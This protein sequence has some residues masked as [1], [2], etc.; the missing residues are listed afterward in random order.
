MHSINEK[1]KSLELRAEGYSYN[2]IS[3]KLNVPKSTLSNWLKNLPFLPNKT[4]NESVINSQ[5]KAIYASR[6]NRIL[7]LTKA[8]EYA[9]QNIKNLSPREIFLIGMGIYIGEGSKAYNT[10][11]IVNSDPRIIKFALL[12]LKKCFGLSEENIKIRIHIY[13]DNDEKE[14]LKF[15]MDQ[16]QLKK[17]C[18][19]TFYVDRRL[20]KRKNR[21]G[22]LPYGT[23][24]MSVVS[25]GN[26]DFGVLLH[27]K[28]L[29]TI[30]CILN[31]RD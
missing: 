28:I 5:Q 18:F 19:Q 6:S 20:N 7:S 2:Y 22:V 17:D 23:A 30:D 4:T 24:H 11:R 3:R 9:E 16:L 1:K 27:R 15:W 13:P 21:A 29:A 8:K 12:W 31:T 14:T 26:K 10:T 25:K